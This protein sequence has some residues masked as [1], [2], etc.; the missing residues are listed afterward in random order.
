MTE[1]DYKKMWRS[2]QTLRVKA[3]NYVSQLLEIIKK[4][5]NGRKQKPNSSL[6]TKD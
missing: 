4:L 6:Q 2:E 3:Q 5:E 1:T